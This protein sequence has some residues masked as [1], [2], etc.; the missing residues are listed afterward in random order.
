MMPKPT[1]ES[2]VISALARHEQA[3]GELGRIKKGIVTELERCPITIEAYANQDLNC[4]F[5]NVSE[6]DHRRL[7]DGSRV[8]HHLHL[9]LQ[10]T[11]ESDRE[12]GPDRKLHDYEIRAELE[13][14]GYDD[15]QPHSCPHC[16]AAWLLIERRKDVR[17][18]LGCARRALRQ[19]GKSALK[20]ML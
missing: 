20:V 4:D 15:D 8:R 7:W 17:Q 11:T 12:Y 14:L 6:D 2:R 1:F 9:T 5:L 18:K 13:G 10:V 3:A 16:L 19:L